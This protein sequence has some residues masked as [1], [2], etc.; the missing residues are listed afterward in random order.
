MLSLGR[1]RGA[2]HLLFLLT[3]QASPDSPVLDV[4]SPTFPAPR[5]SAILPENPG[6]F[7]FSTAPPPSTFSYGFL[8]ETM[9]LIESCYP[10]SVDSLE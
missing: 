9:A 6:L 2:R 10:S 1:I 5:A 8:D 3:R 7:H 4:C